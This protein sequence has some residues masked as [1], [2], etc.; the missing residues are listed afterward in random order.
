MQKE[1]LKER[2]RSGVSLHLDIEQGD[3]V[4][5]LMSRESGLF[6]VTL[7]KVLRLKSPDQLDPD[8]E[9]PDAPWEQSIYLPHGSTDPF[10]ARTIIQTRKLAD[11]FFDRTSEKHRALMDISWEVL[12][13][14]VSLRVI[15]DRLEKRIVEIAT[16]VEGDLTAYTRGIS[17]KPLPMVEYY[18]I[19][20]RSFVNEVRRVLSTISN[21]FAILADKD[22]GQGY[23]HKALEWARKERGEHSLLAQ[24]LSNDQRWLKLWIDMRIAIEHPARDKFI[25]TMNFSLE[26]SRTVR[27]PTWRFVHPDYDMARPQ[28]LLVALEN[29]INNVLKFYED[30][31]V[32]LVDGHLPDSIKVEL[33]FIDEADRDPAA[34]MRF[35]LIPR[36][37]RDD[38]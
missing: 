23:F 38:V 18:D 28:T 2:R 16:I 33:V 9:H 27:L 30:L 29:C 15:K 19:E 35:D 24:M 6:A 22:F 7:K 4:L 14:L 36:V 1:E 17:P 3:R 8:L 32:T 13:S 20:F 26:G 21:L 5:E 10:V 25:E 37:V 11:I 34:P 12:S 31:Q